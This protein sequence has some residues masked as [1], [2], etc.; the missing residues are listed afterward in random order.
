MADADEDAINVNL[1][2]EEDV[3]EEVPDWTAF[4]SVSKNQSGAI[5]KRGEKDFESHGTNTQSQRLDAS[6]QAMHSALS[7][8]RTHLPKKANIAT[9]YPSTNSAYIEVAHSPLFRSIGTNRSPKDDPLNEIKYN[10]NRLWLLPEEILYLIERGTVDCRWPAQE[11]DADDLGLPMSLQGAHAAFIGLADQHKSGLTF[12]RYSVYSYL[13]RAGYHVHRAPT[14]D[15]CAAAF[16]QSVFPPSPSTGA[17]LG[18]NIP[19]LSKWWYS[20][21]DNPQAAASGPLADR[22]IFRSYSDIYQSLSLMDWYDPSAQKD[23]GS[24]PRSQKLQ[25]TWHV[26]KPN[27]AGYKKSRPGPPDFHI[28]VMDSRSTG[29]PSL[30]DLSGLMETQQYIPPP[31]NISLYPKLKHGY[32]SVIL[33]VVDEGVSSFIRL[34][35]AAF[36]LEP[37]HKRDFRPNKGKGGGRRPGGKGG[38]GAAKK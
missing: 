27:N 34:S 38:Q 9:Y 10:L 5:P 23:V 26:W 25:V 18:L 3:E 19:K 28:A 16:D 33:A 13:K 15:T 7:F 24:V 36:G 8:Q 12:E 30:A 31:G 4:A 20:L 22:R 35:D 11:G 37:L 14:W 17:F 29:L 2:E 6:R 1:V 32:K 21:G